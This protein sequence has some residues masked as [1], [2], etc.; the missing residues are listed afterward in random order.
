V[1]AG[2]IATVEQ[3]EKFNNEWDLALE[4]IRPLKYFKMSE[5]ASLRGQFAGW[6]GSDRAKLLRRLIDIVESN[7]AGGIGSVVPHQ[8][9]RDI[10][11]HKIC[12]EMN[13]PYTHCFY[14]IMGQAHRFQARVGDDTEM[15]FVFDEQRG[16][17]GHALKIYRFWL[18]FAPPNLRNKLSNTHPKPANDIDVR[19]LQ[20]ADMLAWRLRRLAEDAYSPTSVANALLPFRMTID[21][22]IWTREKL[23]EAFALSYL[24]KISAPNRYW[25]YELPKKERKKAEKMLARRQP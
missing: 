13:D 15:G 1:L 16:Q 24:S 3:W 4:W 25:P 6:T 17:M 8:H 18:D 20:A 5:A 7:V 11:G 23:S 10:F 22:N 9:Y 2:F 14:D 21:V 19:P 12:R